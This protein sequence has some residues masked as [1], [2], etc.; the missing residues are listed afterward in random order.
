MGVNLRVNGTQEEKLGSGASMVHNGEPHLII[1]PAKN[2][3]NHVR[4]LPFEATS[5]SFEPCSYYLS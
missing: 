2:I 3:L 5:S 1:E 4:I